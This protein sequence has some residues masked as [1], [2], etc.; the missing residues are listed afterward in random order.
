[1]SRVNWT[2]MLHPQCSI[3]A[4]VSLIA[5]NCMLP[6]CCRC[7]TG[8]P[9]DENAILL[10]DTNIG[11]VAYRVPPG[12]T[13]TTLTKMQQILLHQARINVKVTAH[14]LSTLDSMQPRCLG[15]ATPVGTVRRQ[16]ATAEQLW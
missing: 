8:F 6:S 11:C 7:S 4:H 12:R 1:M 15:G 2:Y 9:H 16:V 14:N 10:T 13:K 5:H 3:D